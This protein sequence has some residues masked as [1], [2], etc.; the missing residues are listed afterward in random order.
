MSFVVIIAEGIDHAHG[1]GISSVVLLRIGNMGQ[2]GDSVLLRF[3]VTW[4]GYLAQYLP[5]P[6]HSKVLVQVVNTLMLTQ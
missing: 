3:A 6:G 5:T 2:A 4:Q 1:V